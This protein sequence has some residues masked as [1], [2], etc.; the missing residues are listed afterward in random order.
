METP[1]APAVDTTFV[2]TITPELVGIEN[3]MSL[4]L[5]DENVRPAFLFQSFLQSDRSNQIIQWIKIKFPAMIFAYNLP[6]QA[7]ANWYSPPYS[8]ELRSPEYKKNPT[9]SALRISPLRSGES[10]NY[11]NYQGIFISKTNIIEEGQEISNEKMG[12]LLGYPCYHGYSSLDRIGKVNYVIDVV[13]VTNMGEFIILSNWCDDVSK[14]FEFNNIAT[15]AKVALSKPEHQPNLYLYGTALTIK[16]VK[17][18]VTKEIPTQMILDKLIRGCDDLS[19][20]NTVTWCSSAAIQS[21]E[22]LYFQPEEKDKISNILYN[23]GFSITFQLFFEDN[24]QYTNP[25]HRGILITL[26]LN[27]LNGILQPF[28]PL[29]KY[30]EEG[31][32]KDYELQLTDS[33]RLTRTL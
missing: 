17:V 11:V 6:T 20:Q 16:E 3:I 5:V 21:N 15:R 22:Y 1:I 31:K 26:L 29:Y 12:Q 2:A 28:R 32:L 27:H 33:I 25:I 4:I 30:P 7:T 18:N 9:S 8:Y 14:L 23:L 24:F 10:L 13:V 19:L